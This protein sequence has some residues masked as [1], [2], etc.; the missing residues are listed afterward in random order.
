[1]SWPAPS[2]YQA[3]VQ[4]PGSNFFDP[5][6][7]ACQVAKTRLGL[8]RVAS[9][10]FASVYELHRT[11]ARFAVRC[12]TREVTD[13]DK[14]YNLISQHLA[15]IVSPYLVDFQYLKQGIRVQGQWFPIVKMGWVEGQGL[16]T[17]VEQHLDAPAIL[18]GLAKQLRALV[19]QLRGLNMAHGD[20]QHGNILVTPQA[21]LKLV[22][23][24][25]MFVPA[26]LGQ[27]AAELGH[28]NFQHP[29]RT[30]ADF[31]EQL[32]NF[33]ALVIF[34]SLGA[35]ASNKG[36][37]GKHHNGDNL[38]LRRPDFEA[39]GSS[40]VFKEL[41]TSREPAVRKLAEALRDACAKPPGAVASLE[42]S[43]RTIPS[44]SGVPKLAGP[45]AAT[46]TPPPLTRIPLPTVPKPAVQPSVA[47]VG[48]A[49][50]WR[51]WRVV[52]AVA[53]LV[54]ALG[55][56]YWNF[57]LPPS[58]QDPVVI[59]PGQLKRSDGQVEPSRLGALEMVKIEPGT[60]LM[61]SPGREADRANDEG[62]QT[63]VTISKG[64]WMG[65][66]EVTQGQYEAVMGN[67]P[68]TFK[69]GTNL[70][71]ETVSWLDA[72]NFCAKL[73]ERERQAGRLPTGYVYRLPTEAEWEYAC[74]AGTTTATAYGDSLSS[75][76]A[77]FDGN[78][79]YGGAAKG[80]YL[81]KA[82][83]VGSYA[84]N[85]WGLYD[86]HGNVWEWCLDWY[87]GSLPSGSV[88]DPKGSTSGSSRVDRGGGWGYSGGIC[89]SAIRSYYSPVN[90]NFSIGFRVV[91][92][93]VQAEATVAS[94]PGQTER[95]DGRVE[96][97]RLGALEMVK[98]EPGTF[99]MGSPGSEADRANAE[100]PQTQ[101]TISKG[102]WMGKYEVTQ[103]QYEAVMGNNPSTFKGGTNLPMESVSWLDASNFCAKL[104]ERE[105]HAGRLP[106]G[107]VYRLPTEAEWEYACRA[108]TTTAT[109][110]GD[111]LSSSQANFNGENP[112]GGAAKGASLGRTSKVGSYA[113]NAWG[114]YD[115]HGNVWEWC[116]DW[117]S[118]SL[119]SG[120]VIDPKGSTSGSYRVNRGG[121]WDYNGRYCRSASRYYGSPDYRDGD[122]G[123]RP[124]LAPTQAEA[125][126]A[127]AP[128][129]TE[130]SDGRVEPSRFGA[131]EMVKIEPGTFLMG[132]PGSES[133]RD[134]DEGPQTRVTLSQGFWISKHETTQEE[135]L[136]VMGNNP[137]S[138]TGDL[139]RPVEQV[140]WF[141]ATNYC[142]KLTARERAAG[143][144]P[145]GY[146]YRLPTEAE[147]EYCCRAGTTTATAF[148]NSL[149]SSQ[150]NFDGREP[151]GGA[152]KGPS[153][154]KTSKVGSYAPNAWGLWD[155]HGNV[156]EWCLAWKSESLPGGSV[157]DPKGSTTGSDR[158]LRGGSWFN[159]GRDCRS[160]DRY[161]ASP[162]YRLNN[163]GFRP[164]LA[165]G[166]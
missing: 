23:Y 147:W 152:A 79:P 25:G 74:R 103:G 94:A 135:Y 16:Q 157:T 100:G 66:Y 1:M 86:M 107:Y 83:K 78:F 114:L 34:L 29:R 27:P 141:D 123:F 113:P 31:D 9:G 45:S 67:N 64:F 127:S 75:S 57:Y 143:R 18:Q 126:V 26:M 49:R 39:P 144:L 44:A 108:G 129:Q 65:K 163:M 14:R 21:Q 125:T 77:N 111:S 3:A 160:A 53:F 104:T 63:Q 117:Y 102:F 124:V 128:G 95:S 55:Y 93:P 84:P 134:G 24:D 72:S 90:R 101:V 52:F 11:Q 115:M 96:P 97:S 38:V 92:A 88:I 2:D 5:D 121:S 148:G 138:F 89:R 155:M 131:L 112:Y 6:L 19:G 161:Y 59:V 142:G 15:G 153:L 159:Y 136:A 33:S 10:T 139:K 91:L 47:P 42:F 13:Q 85:A 151:Y 99:L 76:Q 32:D 162:D 150:A 4:N 140:S 166:Q 132:S 50:K 58:Q 12:F 73:T 35:L 70:P 17:Y 56:A 54:C 87:S 146:V 8:P 156:W 51:V 164:V 61:G 71:V 145:V 109:A 119:P 48:P 105:R 98:I 7:R 122:Y 149:S 37:W 68:S 40:A 165:P 158:V 41:L 80:A 20:L 82:S 69:G 120:S 110:Y 60:F 22:D 118:G 30:P 36:L 81:G 46:P 28:A 154:Q 43:L 62:P 130:R 137:S 106:T 133:P 116:L